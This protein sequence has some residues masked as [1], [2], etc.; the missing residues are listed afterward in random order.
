[1]TIPL[2][3][4]SAQGS[5]R[6]RVALIAFVLLV[7]LVL[8]VAFRA[9]Q[10]K[11]DVEKLS[12]YSD[13]L[14]SLSSADALTGDIDDVDAIIATL[15]EVQSQVHGIHSELAFIRL[16]EPLIGWIPLIG[17]DLRAASSI[18]ERAL[19]DVDAAVELALAGRVLLDFG[20]LI[21]GTTQDL[22]AAYASGRT[23][24]S[25]EI[26]SAHI[27]A[28]DEFLQR[29]EE[30]GQSRKITPPD[31]VTQY[32]QILDE[33]E[34]RLREII[35]WTS[36]LIV[37]GEQ[38]GPLLDSTVSL[39][40][41]ASAGG[42]N[43]L[44]TQDE[45]A[46]LL[47]EL[48]AQG[49]LIREPAKMVR[50]S[51]PAD[52]KDTALGKRVTALMSAL[53]SIEQ[54]AQGARTGLAAAEPILNFVSESNIRLL[55][56]G[57]EIRE[58][59]GLLEAARPELESSVNQIA[60]ATRDISRTLDSSSSGVAAELIDLAR[61]VSG[62]LQIAAT[63]PIIADELLGLSGPRTHLVL[64]QTSDEL[65][66]SGGFVSGI[67]LVT[68]DGGALVSS[69]YVDVVEVDDISRLGLYPRPPQPL[70]DHMAAS[71]W[72]MRDVGW[73]P[74]FPSTAA[75]ARSLLFLGQQ[76]E[77]D[78][79]IALT[80]QAFIKVADALGGISSAAGLLSADE[81][82]PILE[83]GTDERGREFMDVLFQ[84]LIDTVNGPNTSHRALDLA[85]AFS[86]ALD[87]KN[88]MVNMSG[89]AAQDAVTTN[90]WAGHLSNP[91]LSPERDRLTPVDSNIGWSKV[92]RNIERSMEYSISLVE[93]G[94]PVARVRLE[95]QNHSGP[96]A[97]NCD[98]QKMDRG[99]AYHLLKNACYW[100]FARIF[101]SPDAR[102]IS[103]DALPLPEHSVQS[104]TG[105]KAAGEDTFEMGFVAGVA[106]FGGLKTVPAN[107]S[108]TIEFTYDLP[109]TVVDWSESGARYV[110]ELQAQAG[111]A[112][113]ATRISVN[114][115]DGYE[116]AS[117]NFAPSLTLAGKVEFGFNLITDTV[118]ELE[119][120]KVGTSG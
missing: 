117:S 105:F 5:I 66:A 47:D 40:N 35:D 6:V 29:A 48:A 90:G 45:V 52:L 110:L 102:L 111:T 87:Q 54:F 25:L 92:D 37:V 74:D 100:N 78:A 43:G 38:L 119:L 91:N 77:V 98:E 68:F 85:S 56:D 73:E 64:G 50:L 33:Q 20:D 41:L 112:G 27:A 18:G 79:V 30:I 114:L 80:P 83:V 81:L 24:A 108:A 116:Y 106:Y 93:A 28:A 11:G 96:G 60:R 107:E 7:V 109:A 3:L 86:A 15:Q 67:W 31:F 4:V 65:R 23:P 82:L 39:L 53:E 9:A 19:A 76:R 95:Y 32:V 42:I 75:I 22:H 49:G 10:I 101:V 44:A 1:M 71:V 63:L 94:R 61:D 89:Q 69:E 113:R 46:A 36:A 17:S 21:S 2:S 13:D 14:R 104:E 57:A 34:P 55:S 59:I 51:A 8:G 70:E 62:A 97:S 58:M 84:G 72:L 16:A 115:P 118:L 99:I 26:V 103:S 120:T 12:E 88:I